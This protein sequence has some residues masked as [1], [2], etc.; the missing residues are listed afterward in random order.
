MAGGN[1]AHT[2]LPP[3]AIDTWYQN[4]EERPGTQ[5][6]PTEVKIKKIIVLI[7]VKLINLIRCW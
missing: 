1:F 6:V 3:V 2:L 7:N 5:G 4:N